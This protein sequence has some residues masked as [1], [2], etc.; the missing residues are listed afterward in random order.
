M[1]DEP[2]TTAD[3]TFEAGGIESAVIAG[4][5]MTRRPSSGSRAEKG[6]RAAATADN[7]K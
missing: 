4:G 5:Q 3:E 7:A 1:K 6:E 2:T